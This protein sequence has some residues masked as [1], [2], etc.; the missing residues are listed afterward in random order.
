MSDI[1]A[2]QSETMALIDTSK[3]LVDKVLN[4]VQEIDANASLSLSFSTNPIGYLIQ[5]LKTLGVTKQELINFLSNVLLTVTPIMEVSVKAVLLTNFKSMVSCSTDPTIPA[6]YRKKHSGKTSYEDEEGTGIDISI[7]AIDY[8]DKL[9]VNPLSETGRNLY[10]GL[11]GVTDVYKLTRATDFDAFLWF[12]IHK[13]K[14]PNSVK[15]T[16]GLSN[17]NGS[18]HKG[19]N[20]ASYK[21][22]DGTLLNELDYTFPEA[23]GASIQL[24]NTFTYPTAHTI[25]MCVDRQYDSILKNSVISA[26]LLPVSDDWNSVNWYAPNKTKSGNTTVR[27][28]DEERALCN[29]QY[30]GEASK[31]SSLTTP[32]SNKLRFTILP[33][34]LITEPRVSEGDL[35]WRYKKWRFNAQGKPDDN[36]KYT[37][38][39]TSGLKYDPRT[40]KIKGK[41]DPQALYECYPGLT[42]Y[43]F[44]YDYIMSLKLFDEKVLAA[45]LLTSL[46]NINISA[47]G[48]ANFSLTQNSSETTEYI[49][50][51]VKNIV[52]SD[53]SVTTDCYYTFSNSKYDGQLQRAQER[54]A[55]INN[56]KFSNARKILNE[57]DGITSGDTVNLHKTQETLT[58][59]IA[60]A[61]VDVTSGVSSNDAASVSYSFT[62]SLIENLVFA[63][64]ECVLSPKV[65]LLLEVN[66]QI[67][68]KS[69]TE[70]SVA[71]LIKT[72]QATITEIVQQVVDLIIQ[73][74]LTYVLK[75]L[76]PILA[77]VTVAISI[78]SMTNY[79]KILLDIIENCPVLWF[80]IGNSYS[81]TQLDQVDYADI[82]T[83]ESTK[84]TKTT[85][86]C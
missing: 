32:A 49:R 24:G 33:K 68:G 51:I 44:N 79:A 81:P 63:L 55:N 29:L 25:S 36:G 77:K 38:D 15:I 57:L 16:N 20:G 60:Q 47:G 41:A 9:S 70:F 6:K 3:A 73:E 46:E 53:N 5:I 22:K 56:S 59:A 13:G 34:P 12:V 19:C 7:S 65:L 42:I 82:D 52:N 71:D 86:N 45:T 27:V 18:V 37:L 21:P 50:N 72:M 67:M 74:L 23:N 28:Y 1:K 66:K 4:I 75:L 31:M 10:F 84:E 30:V 64:V 62:Y 26:K 40:G 76:K 17:L 58:R 8:L 48:S 69:A 83:T 35:P 78:E 14:F 43:E 61:S 11:N 54:R 39:N 80:S 85:N 2:L